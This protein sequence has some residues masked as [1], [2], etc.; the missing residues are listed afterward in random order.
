VKV[1][2]EGE[3]K[4]PT[5]RLKKCS[6]TYEEDAPTSRAPANTTA[7]AYQSLSG[8]RHAKALYEYTNSFSGKGCSHV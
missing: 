5:Y 8:L 4:L 7:G 1:D 3:F 2:D 6:E